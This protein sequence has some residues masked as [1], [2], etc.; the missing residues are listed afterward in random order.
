[1]SEISFALEVDVF[2]RILR[3][4]SCT[5]SAFRVPLTRGKASSLGV[6]DAG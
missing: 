4:T 2:G 5:T 6:R 1:M 3:K